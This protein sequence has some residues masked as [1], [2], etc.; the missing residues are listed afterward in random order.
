MRA[1]AH[2]QAAAAAAVQATARGSPWPAQ[3]RAA[4]RCGALQPPAAQSTRESSQPP[5]QQG[6]KCI[7]RCHSRHS[8]LGEALQ[9]HS[10]I[11]GHR[12]PPLHCSACFIHSLKH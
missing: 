5:C 1:C 10:G 9:R 12:E 11:E 2:R 6:Q 4:V 3:A 7:P 8:M